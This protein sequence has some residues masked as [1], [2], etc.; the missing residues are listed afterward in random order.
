MASRSSAPRAHAVIG[1]D[2]V[3]ARKHSVI[4]IGQT[5][6]QAAADVGAAPVPAAVVG[7][8]RVAEGARRRGEKG[9]REGARGALREEGDARVEAEG[10]VLEDGRVELTVLIQGWGRG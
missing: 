2:K 8:E 10:E 9:R 6:D 7:A 4:A 3:I 5:L 1:A